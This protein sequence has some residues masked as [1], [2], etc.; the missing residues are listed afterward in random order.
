VSKVLILHV[1]ADAGLARTLLRA[2]ADRDPALSTG[3]C[4][5]A[6]PLSAAAEDVVVAI[7]SQDALAEPAFQQQIETA[8]ERAHLLAA[9]LNGAAVPSRLLR[10]S[11]KPATT[12][13]L[14]EET[15]SRLADWLDRPALRVGPFAGDRHSAMQS[16]ATSEPAKRP[17]KA[18]PFAASTAS[19]PR[20]SA[21][22]ERPAPPPPP[23]RI[24][25]SRPEP[26][27]SHSQVRRAHTWKRVA[28]FT[29]VLLLAIVAIS[30]PLEPNPENS[31]EA[32]W[33]VALTFLLNP[34]L[35][36]GC[37]LLAWSIIDPATTSRPLLSTLGA[38][39]LATAFAAA[40][41]GAGAAALAMLGAEPFAQALAVLAF[42]M[43]VC[44]CPATLLA[45][46]IDQWTVRRGIRIGRA[47]PTYLAMALA[48]GLVLLLSPSVRQAA[49]D[50]VLIS[51]V[52]NHLARVGYRVNGKL[53]RAE[54]ELV[55]ARRDGAGKVTIA[56]PG[57]AFANLV[58]RIR[59]FQSSTGL[60]ADGL[61][62]VALLERLEAT[63]TRSRWRLQPDGK[64]DAK[65][66]TEVFLRLG[67]GAIVELSPGEY[68]CPDNGES[69]MF[70]IV[71]P[72][73]DELPALT[74][75]GTGRADETI[76]LCSDAGDYLQLNGGSR[77]ETLTIR[78]DGSSALSLGGIDERPI[79]VANIRLVNGSLNT[80]GATASIDRL[81]APSISISSG[82]VS[83]KDSELTGGGDAT[84]LILAT[85]AVVVVEG[86][87]FPR[88]GAASAIR[89]E[90][91]ADEEDRPAGLS[92]FTDNDVHGGTD[93]RLPAV[94]VHAGR[95]E[96]SNNRFEDIAGPCIL[97]AS[98]AGGQVHRNRLDRCGTSGAPAIA[99]AVRSSANIADN[100]IL[101]PGGVPILRAAAVVREGPV[102]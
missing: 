89:Y 72:I 21:K 6:S 34:L 100:D 22:D 16:S 40:S 25:R 1:A 55:D 98:E 42:G 68:E 41:T 24:V 9:R 92:R 95:P 18:A 87:R 56:L 91:Y 19:R 48:A 44:L 39:V 8:A 15:A 27:A 47:A 84:A 71:S 66:L 90:S 83:I 74:L 57:E 7:V 11:F 17:E 58:A 38:G 45:A 88:L 101:R 33:S 82:E 77:I 75:R 46:G 50:N 52:Q 102:R 35:G 13:Q 73:H 99:A 64:G 20:A 3:L 63:P 76:I 80:S 94:F 53:D 78:G 81:V 5:Q 67:D 59:E 32:W 97:I 28:G 96:V 49:G 61:V 69:S 62:T 2:L 30:G 60:P 14:I 85:D 86:S 70:D 23:P 31:A 4:S 54:R 43:L 12:E 93:P 29:A 37:S 51:D 26:L 36:F 79:E 10:W 65:D